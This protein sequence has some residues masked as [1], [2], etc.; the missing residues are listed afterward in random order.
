MAAFVFRFFMCNPF[1]R[2][3]GL[4]LGMLGMLGNL[5]MWGML[6]SLGML[7]NLGM[8]GM[9]GMFRVTQLSSEK[10]KAWKLRNPWLEF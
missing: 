2:S 8:L 4:F 3:A 1:A 10:R 6:G 5:G 9:L 7:G